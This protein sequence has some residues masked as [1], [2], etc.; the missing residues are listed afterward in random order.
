MFKGFTDEDLASLTTAAWYEFNTQ[1]QTVITEGPW[2]DTLYFILGT[3]S[4]TFPDLLDDHGRRV[5]NAPI[6]AYREDTH[7]LVETQT[8]DEN[9]SATFT[10]LPYGQDI[11]FH[12]KWGGIAENKKERWFF[13]DF[14]DI[15]EGGTGAT[16][17]ADARFNLGLVIGT[18]V[19]AWDDDLD[20]IAALS[21]ADSNFIV[22][23][24]ENWRV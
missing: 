18:N 22:G 9:G 12:A 11:I 16:S 5:K 8:T 23:D 17:G 3:Y 21:P 15:E 14:K 2:D 19:Q 24:G 10:S 7:A 1:A 6:E 4:F 13:L 20:D